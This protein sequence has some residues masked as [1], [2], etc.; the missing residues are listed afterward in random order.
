[1]QPTAEPYRT[2][3]SKHMRQTGSSEPALPG[4]GRDRVVC[5]RSTWRMPECATCS[6]ATHTRLDKKRQ[7]RPADRLCRADLARTSLPR[8][9]GRRRRSSQPTAS[10][11]SGAATPLATELCW[12][13]ANASVELPKTTLVGVWRGEVKGQDRVRGNGCCPCFHLA[14]IAEPRAEPQ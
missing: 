8:S 10:A 14:Q 4:C 2:T 12:G 5:M 7:R 9:R 1:M 13:I 11:R 3:L 6:Q